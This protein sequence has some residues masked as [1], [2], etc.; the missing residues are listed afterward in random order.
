RFR[1]IGLPH[2]RYYIDFGSLVTIFVDIDLYLVRRV[3]FDDFVL[4]VI[5]F[6]VVHRGNFPAHLLELAPIKILLLSGLQGLLE[7]FFLT[8]RGFH[9]ISVAETAWI[10]SRPIWKIN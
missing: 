6:I 4:H 10:G 3:T 8:F 2:I 7:F 5:G 9:A 1:C